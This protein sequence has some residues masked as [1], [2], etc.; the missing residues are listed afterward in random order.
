MTSRPRCCCA[1]RTRPRWRPRSGA[2]GGRDGRSRGASLLAQ[3][4]T[5]LDRIS[6]PGGGPSGVNEDVAGYGTLSAWVLD[7]ATGLAD[8]R[9]L[10]G[11]SDAAWLADAYDDLLRTHADREDHGPRRLLTELIETVAAIF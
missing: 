9:L 2:S 1:S 3:V 7:G 8:G 4:L 11:P 5:V 10:P 6:D